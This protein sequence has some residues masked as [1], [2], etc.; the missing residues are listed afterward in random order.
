MVDDGELDEDFPPLERTQP[1]TGYIAQSGRRGER[2]G[3]AKLE[4][5]FAL[6]EAMEEQCLFCGLFLSM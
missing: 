4:G 2:G 5:E 1:I 6:A 3:V